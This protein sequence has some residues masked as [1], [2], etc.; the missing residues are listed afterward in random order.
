MGKKIWRAKIIRT[1]GEAGERFRE[2]YSRMLRGL[3]FACQLGFN[4]EPHTMGAIR[5]FMPHV[6]DY[7]SN[8]FGQYARRGYRNNRA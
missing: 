4:I 7:R 5:V 2:D 6:N 8:A 3:R 1:V